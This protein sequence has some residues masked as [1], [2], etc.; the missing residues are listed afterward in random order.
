M[1]AVL[2][3]SL[4]EVALHPGRSLARP[5]AGDL[6]FNWVSQ[7]LEAYPATRVNLALDLINE[8]SNPKL[9]AAATIL[10]HPSW[11]D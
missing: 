4:A 10:P 7:E 11:G 8:A 1:R 2:S 6:D 5:M 9:L 3:Q